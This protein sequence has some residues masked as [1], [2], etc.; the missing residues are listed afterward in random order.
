MAERDDQIA[1]EFPFFRVYKDGR[2]VVHQP[3]TEKITPSDDP[4]TGVR[5]KDAIVSAEPPVSV[6]IF[7]PKITDPS[8]KLPVLLYIHGGGYCM[9]SAFSSQYHNY[10]ATV[11]AEANVLAVSVEYGLFPTRPIPACYED[12]WAALQWIASHSGRSGPE[13]W[14]NDHADF[15]RVFIAGDSAGGNITHTLVSRVGKLGLSGVKIIGA[16]LMHPFFG[17]TVDDHMWLYMCPENEGLQDR[18]M[19]PAVEDLKRLG[20][21]RVLVFAAE[22]DHLF[23]PGRNYVREL[24]KS[25][26]AGEAELVENWGC[27]HCFHILG[28]PREGKA[29]DLLQKF[30]AFIKQEC[31][32]ELGPP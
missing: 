12:S 19:K 4:I 15:D 14:L 5:P 16:V 27:E 22:K 31:V 26:W 20:C 11:A 25:G 18:R 8:E 29:E 28:N 10:V 21:E 24:K 7:L 23:E 30:V 3:L 6:R 9:Q 32:S 2:V 1:H 13:S 17:G